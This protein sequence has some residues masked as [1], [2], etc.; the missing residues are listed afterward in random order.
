M[1]AKLVK[2]RQMLAGHGHQS[3]VHAGGE[4]RAGVRLQAHPVDQVTG[5][6][7]LVDFLKSNRAE[8]KKIRA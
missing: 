7:A 8:R 2:G 5:G 1:A 3:S 6:V 4:L